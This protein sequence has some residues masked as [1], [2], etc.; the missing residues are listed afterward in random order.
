[1]TTKMEI[2]QADKTNK[3][4]DEPIRIRNSRAI[5]KKKNEQELYFQ[6]RRNQF[7]RDNRN[8]RKTK[9]AENQKIKD[10]TT[11]RTE[12]SSDKKLNIVILFALST[13]ARAKLLGIKKVG[14]YSRM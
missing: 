11:R 14:R 4:H 10:R 8:I 12:N 6:M 1:M 7:D 9:A 3:R 5:A 13:L 2:F